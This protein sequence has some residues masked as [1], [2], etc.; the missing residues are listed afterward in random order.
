MK[1]KKL[2]LALL[3][4][5]AMLCPHF[6]QV[7]AEETKAEDEITFSDDSSDF[8]MLSDV[9]PDAIL[10]IRY[11]S[12]YN[13]V[14]KRI[15]GYEEPVALL[16]SEAASALKEVSDELTQKGYRLKIFDAYRPQM[17]VTNF[18]NWALD[19]DDTRMKEYFYP[20]LDKDVLFPQG[21][22]N[23]HSGHSRGSTVDLTLFDMTTEKEVDMGGTFDYFG[24]LSHPDYKDITEE[25]YNNRM[26]LREA[27]LA[28]GFKPL[29]EEWWH[30]TLEDEPYPDTYFTFPVNSDSIVTKDADI[31]LG[32]KGYTLEQVVV[33]SRHNLRA[34][35]SSNGSV[36]Q[37]LTPHSWIEWSANSSELTINGGIQETSMGQYFRKWLDEE[38][39]IPENSVPEEEEIRFNARDKQ[40]CRA[41]ARYFAAG[42]LP[43]T[44]VTVEYPS[45]ANGPEDFMSPVLKF[46]SE[47]YAADA[48]KQVEDMGGA[49]GFEGLSDETRDA[50]RLIMDTADVWDS[51]IYKSGKYGD[52]L[53]DGSGYTMEA[54]GEP[55]VT[56]A[57]K[58]ASQLGDALV[59]QY[60]E[61]PDKLKAAFG[62]ELTDED[63]ETIG[64]FMT[65]Y[66]ELKHGAPMVAVNITHPLIEELESELK[67]EDRKFSF[68]CAHD[69]TV[70]GALSAL[71]AEPYSLPE[72]IE[73]R[74]PIGVKLLFERW[75][76]EDGKAWYRVDLVYRSTEQIRDSAVL[77]PENPPMRYDLK[78][79]DVETNEDGL[80]SEEDLFDMFD[81][82]EAE[83][84]EMKDRYSK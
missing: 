55:D 65:R 66:L 28:H 4:L 17:A 61:E 81:R 82:T 12:T 74:T 51:E 76:D 9:V 5:F 20:E 67:N 73:T 78:F 26:I 39:L 43:L 3:L 68:F 84:E 1:Q 72:S 63:W 49:E 11:Y 25:Q 19:P 59:L 50:I 34:P 57:I 79:E 80:I 56:G 13:F 44:D 40:R 22:I 77:T 83:Y 36:P 32:E 15:D 47:D 38:G 27:M 7:M 29:A 62:H 58:T 31:Q 16:T 53:T 18:M 24:E 45:E 71:G 35:L 75:R 6:V 33:L 14:G 41:T 23:E 42:M 48:V 30:F 21:Y 54:D 10:E 37:E 52:L 2:L 46:Y 64:G 8:V 69:C 70:H 60:Y